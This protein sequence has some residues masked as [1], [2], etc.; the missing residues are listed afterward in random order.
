MENISV[1]IFHGKTNFIGNSTYLL[2][3]DNI[4]VHLSQYLI[5]K[6]CPNMV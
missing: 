5:G 4:I 1:R 3:P 2:V 6:I